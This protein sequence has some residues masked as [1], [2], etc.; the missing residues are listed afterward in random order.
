VQLLQ[1]GG[2][3]DDGADGREAGV[4]DLPQRLRTERAGAAAA[5]AGGVGL[6]GPSAGLVQGGWA[7]AAVGLVGV[8]GRGIG[9]HVSLLSIR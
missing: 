3:H 9:R 6:V 7:G 1:V 8:V 5:P 4:V 2:G